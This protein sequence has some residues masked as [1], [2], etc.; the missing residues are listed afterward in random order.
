MDARG[1]AEDQLAQAQQKEAEVGLVRKE[2]AVR[3]ENA[4]QSDRRTKHRGPMKAK[5]EEMPS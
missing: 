5:T 2:A 1:V 4:A 3:C